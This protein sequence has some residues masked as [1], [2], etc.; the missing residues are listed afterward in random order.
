MPFTPRAKRLVVR[1]KTGK[2]F[3]CIMCGKTYPL[4][5]AVHIIDKKEWKAKLGQDSKTNG[6]PLCPNCHRIFDEEL[7][8]HLYRALNK[9]GATEL[10]NSW[11]K[12]NKLSVTGD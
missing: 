8:P 10:P 4:P 12:N 5:D 11:M 6:M 9:F 7:R 3:P 2:H 1:D